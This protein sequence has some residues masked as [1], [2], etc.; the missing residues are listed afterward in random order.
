MT[1]QFLPTPSRRVRLFGTVQIETDQ[2][3]VH[4]SGSRIQSLF[5]FLVLH[6]HV[7]HSRDY[8]ADLLYPDAPVERVRRYLSD[9]LYRLRQVLGE[10]WLCGDSQRVG[11][12]HALDLWVDVW[13]FERLYNAGERA[14]LQAAV[15]LYTGDVLSEIYD[16]WILV[17]RVALHEKY[18]TCLMRLG[19]ATEQRNQPQAALEYY[20]RLVN[21]DPLREE[22]QRGLMRMYARLGRYRAAIQQYDRLCQLLIEELKSTPLPET[23]ALATAIRADYQATDKAAVTPQ[24]FVGRRA[25]RSLLLRAVEQAQ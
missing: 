9:T 14:D 1:Q 25:E 11:H 2:S 24:P 6:P 23:V 19:E 7:T 21:V 5:A 3:V 13:E 15:G 12:N 8:L 18:L 22:A 10:E 20:Y 16:D 4:L 17:H